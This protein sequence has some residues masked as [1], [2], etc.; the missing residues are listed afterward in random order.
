M[1][2]FADAHISSLGYL[3]S[4]WLWKSM[5][6]QLWKSVN[7]AQKKA[8]QFYLSNY[9]VG[10]NISNKHLWIFSL[11]KANWKARALCINMQEE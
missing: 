9:S 7:V 6:Q 4:F 8:A 3:W 5:N 2:M 1:P 10:F 11:W